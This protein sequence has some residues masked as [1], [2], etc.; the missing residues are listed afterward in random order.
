MAVAISFV[1]VRIRIIIG[2]RQDAT[3]ASLIEIISTW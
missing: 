3:T 1:N 2:N